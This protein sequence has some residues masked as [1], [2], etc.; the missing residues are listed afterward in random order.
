MKLPCR[1]WYSK[2]HDLGSPG[3]G[4]SS[5]ILSSLPGL[6]GVQLESLGEAIEWWFLS[7]FFSSIGVIQQLHINLFAHDTGFTR[8]GEQSFQQ[9]GPN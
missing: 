8:A 5:P 4:L 9:E 2:A 3:T 1:G 7:K 6:L